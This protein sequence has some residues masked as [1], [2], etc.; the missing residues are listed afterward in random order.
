METCTVLVAV[1][2]ADGRVVGGVSYVPGPGPWADRAQD[3]EAEFRMLVVDPE[4]QRLGIGEALVRRCIELAVAGQRARLIL[5]TEASMTSAH[6]I[7]DR[8]GFVR[9]PERDW[10]HPSVHLMAYILDLSG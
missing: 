8:L 9:T 7:Y 10:D 6:R 4:H 3:D 5:L 2:D 1:D